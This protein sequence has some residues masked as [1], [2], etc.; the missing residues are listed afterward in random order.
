M[1]AE[2]IHY[3]NDIRKSDVACGKETPHYK[4]GYIM[5]THHFRKTTCPECIEMTLSNH[6]VVSYVWGSRVA[7]KVQYRTG[8]AHLVITYR[9]RNRPDYNEWEHETL[10]GIYETCGNWEYSNKEWF[11]GEDGCK[12]CQKIYRKLNNI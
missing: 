4:D 12:K 7:G 11:E 1:T 9:L 10:C 8:K 6:N 2:L 5:V 3:C